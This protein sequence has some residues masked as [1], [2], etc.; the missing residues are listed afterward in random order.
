MRHAHARCRGCERCKRVVTPASLAQDVRLHGVLG[1]PMLDLEPYIGA[2]DWDAVDAEIRLALTKCELDWCGEQMK[3]TNW[4]H[5]SALEGYVDAKDVIAGFGPEEFAAFLKLSDDIDVNSFDLNHPEQYSMG[6]QTRIPFSRKQ[7]DYLK[8]RYGVRF[9]WICYSLMPNVS[10]LLDPGAPGSRHPDFTAEV[11]ALFPK[12][13]ELIRALPLSSVFQ[14]TIFAVD[15]HV[16]PV[17]H[18][19]CGS[20]EQCSRDPHHYVL[21][22][23]GGD[24]RQFVC[25][26]AL[27][28]KHYGPSRAFWFNDHDYHGTEA[29]PFFRYSIQVNGHFDPSFF[30]QLAMRSKS[31]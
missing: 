29:D 19:D 22:V 14:C 12:T 13:L 17:L 3:S 2:V 28:Q 9:D 20:D 23:P 21:L 24:L 7:V 8:Y 4:I 10:E 31:G 18:R 26:K 1:Q 15:A 25:D 16:L 5:P 30:A 27:T 11:R 6:S